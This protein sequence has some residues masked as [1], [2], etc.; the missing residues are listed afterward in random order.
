M[1]LGAATTCLALAQP[2]SV[3]ALSCLDETY[4]ERVEL[5]L[6]SVEVD[7]SVV[8]PSGYDEHTVALIAGGSDDGNARVHL[9]LYNA[10]ARWAEGYD[11]K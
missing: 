4:H 8:I 6:V 9:E 1:L 10:V 3:N 7:G 2:S 5:E 11:A